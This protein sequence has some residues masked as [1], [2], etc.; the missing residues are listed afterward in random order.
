MHGG[1]SSPVPHF[2]ITTM[3]EVVVPYLYFHSLWVQ[4]GYMGFK[5]WWV[6]YSNLISFF[7]CT[8]QRNAVQVSYQNNLE[9]ILKSSWEWIFFINSLFFSFF[10]PLSLLLHSL[11]KQGCT[12]LPWHNAAW[13]R[14]TE[15]ICLCGNM[16]TWYNDKHRFFFFYASVCHTVF[17]WMNTHNSCKWPST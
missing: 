6:Q 11:L 4:G 5:L 9:P 10:I 12:F 7:F 1:C 3:R 17:I 8:L 14:N 16:K 13:L 2:S 15:P